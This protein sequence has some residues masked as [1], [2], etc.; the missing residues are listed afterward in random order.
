MKTALKGLTEKIEVDR[1]S[2]RLII[3]AS[4]RIISEIGPSWRSST[5]RR[6]R[7]CSSA[8]RQEVSTDDII[9]LGIDWNQLSRQ[10]FVFVEG[11]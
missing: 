3:V 4:P 10:S 9:K 7:S 6:S 11:N 8:H 1:G 2:N 5:A